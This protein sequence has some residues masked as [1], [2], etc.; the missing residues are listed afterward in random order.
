MHGLNHKAAI[1]VVAALC[2][3]STANTHV[4]QSLYV[5]SEG[6]GSNSFVGG[7]ATNV[8]TMGAN[9][10]ASTTIAA[11]T[12]PTT[13]TTVSTTTP[14]PTTTSAAT[15]TAQGTTTVQPTAYHNDRNDEQSAYYHDH[16]K[17]EHGNERNHRNER[18]HGN[19]PDHDTKNDN[20]K[21]WLTEVASPKRRNVVLRFASAYPNR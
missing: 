19:R 16:G 13:E 1:L 14:A 6:V 2:L 5:D 21:Q 15:T 17:T 4:T 10:T 8:T 18:N 3:L 9:E 20:R 7:N 11:T 12:P